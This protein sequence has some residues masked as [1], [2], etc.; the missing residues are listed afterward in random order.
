VF[1]RVV[2]ERYGAAG[3]QLIRARRKARVTRWAHLGLLAMKRGDMAAA[4]HAFRAALREDPRRLKNLLR[5]LRT[6]LPAP[7]IRALTGRTRGG[8]AES[9]KS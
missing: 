1:V 7:L 6:Y 2:R 5:W 3:E 8:A 9:A 4:R